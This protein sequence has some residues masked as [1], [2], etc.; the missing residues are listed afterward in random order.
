MQRSLLFIFSLLISFSVFAQTGIEFDVQVSKKVV[1]QGAVFSVLILLNGDRGTQFKGPDFKDFQS[2]SGPSIASQSLIK[3]G[4]KSMITR[5]NYEILATNVGT[6]TVEPARVKVRGNFYE[7]KP[8]QIEVVQGKKISS[9]EGLNNTEDYFVRLETIDSI[10]Y[11]GQQIL[12]Q[13]KVYS[14]VSI[15]SYK[16]L[17]EPSFDAFYTLE[18]RN[19]RVP[20]EVIQINGETYN[21]SIIKNIPLFPQQ[22]GQY[23]IDPMHL[24]LGLPTG[25]RSR[26]FFFSEQVKNVPVTTNRLKIIVKDLPEG[27]PTTFSGAIGNYELKAGI[28]QNELSTDDAITMQIV[29]TGNGDPKMINAPNISFDERFESYDPSISYENTQERFGVQYHSTV[30]EYLLVPLEEGQYVLNPAF[31][32]YD[33]EGS[34]F[35]TLQE[36][37]FDIQV[38]KG[39]LDRNLRTTRKELKEEEIVGV[40]AS[41]NLKKGPSLVTRPISYGLFAIPLLGFIGVFLL[42]KKKQALAAKDPLE[43]K[44]EQANKVA[45]SHLAFAK[46]HMNENNQ[47]GFYKALSTALLGYV[48]DKL[49]LSPSDISKANVQDQLAQLH[50]DP[51]QIEAFVQI[52]KTSELALYGASSP[53]GMERNFAQAKE[54]LIKIESAF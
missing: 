46:E 14:R 45:L 41:T 27:A 44:R 12:L 25:K 29:V 36:G 7:T 48:S 13:V 4:V 47:K 37:P 17:S 3:N 15:K 43:L 22:T 21:A 39:K 2:I 51:F 33:T 52:L 32:F 11:V 20:A 26:S 6:F 31:S 34:R 42:Q 50:V 5:Y 10:A 9:G 53:G 19:P 8:V 16:V 24:S 23:T 30:F 18:A 1:T 28:N 38:S 40:V 54:L 35:V 49:N